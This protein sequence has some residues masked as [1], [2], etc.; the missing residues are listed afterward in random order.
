MLLVGC[1]TFRFI[2]RKHTSNPL[3]ADTLL[4]RFADITHEHIREAVNYLEK[5]AEKKLA[6]IASSTDG[7]F[8][9][10]YGKLEGRSLCRFIQL[11]MEG[12][13]SEFAAGYYIY[14]WV[15]AMSIDAFVPLEVDDLDTTAL[16][17][18]GM[19]YRDTILALG[20]SVSF[21]QVFKNCAVMSPDPKLCSEISVGKTVS[22]APSP[23]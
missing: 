13:G 20:G 16:R 10:V 23:F 22:S 5:F 19:H 15:E 18:A 3:L 9:S 12:H 8:T 1:N 4:P 17:K 21:V 6:E 14:L 2:W 7:N 11:A